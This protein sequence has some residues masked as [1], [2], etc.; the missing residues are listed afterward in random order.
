M[1]RRNGIPI[2]L[3]LAPWNTEVPQVNVVILIVRVLATWLNIRHLMGMVKREESKAQGD[4]LFQ[5]QK[6]FY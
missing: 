3:K 2:I 4:W 5:G 6:R 1:L